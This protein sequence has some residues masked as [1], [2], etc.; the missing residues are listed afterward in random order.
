MQLEESLRRISEVVSAG[1]LKNTL[2]AEDMR[3]Y[4]IGPLCATSVC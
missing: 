2:T 1:L 3:Y 4:G